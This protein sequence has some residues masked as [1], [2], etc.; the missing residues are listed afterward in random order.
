LTYRQYSLAEIVQQSDLLGTAIAGTD[1]A[2]AVPR[3]H[4]GS[5]SAAGRN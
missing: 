4:S 5:I 1:L 3:P 2:V